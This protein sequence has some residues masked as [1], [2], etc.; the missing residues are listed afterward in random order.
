MFASLLFYIFSDSILQS[1]SVLVRLRISD[2]AAEATSGGSVGRRLSVLG[3]F[4]SSRVKP[5]GGPVLGPCPSTSKEDVSPLETPPGPEPCKGAMEGEDLL[6]AIKDTRS[7]GKEVLGASV[8]PHQTTMAGGASDQGGCRNGHGA[9]GSGRPTGVLVEHNTAVQLRTE[10]QLPAVSKSAEAQDC[11]LPDV[12]RAATAPAPYGAAA[13]QSLRGTAD[14][15]AMGGDG[16]RGT[17]L[18]AGSAD[19]KMAPSSL[20]LLLPKPVSPLA[21]TNGQRARLK[22][23]PLPSAPGK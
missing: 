1:I 16:Q 12:A 17:G 10:S 4:I 22:L 7:F 19:A 3:S 13:L 21:P 5:A 2:A 20:E 23:S 15:R 6:F 11:S 8:M 14:N 9:V 18:G